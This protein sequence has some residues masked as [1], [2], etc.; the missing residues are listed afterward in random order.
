MPRP[1]TLL[2][3]MIVLV[4]AAVLMAVVI[5]RIG[6][7]PAGLVV[8]KACGD[9]E[10]AVYHAARRARVTGKPTRLTFDLD[11]HTATVEETGGAPPPPADDAEAAAE[12]RAE[13]RPT[14]P[15]VHPLDEAIGREAADGTSEPD[16]AP[17]FVFYPNGE[18]G[19]TTL[20]FRVRGRSLV[21]DV[22]PLTGR[23]LITAVENQ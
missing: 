2:E 17:V 23:P 9:F 11:R 20:P 13:G 21:L 10:N 4:V 6:R 1:F 14:E 5:P 8:E 12:D 16:S 22:D 19:G 3:L 18:A 15:L 7:L